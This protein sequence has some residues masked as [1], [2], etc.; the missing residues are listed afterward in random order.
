MS[1]DCPTPQEQESSLRN[2]GFPAD[3]IPYE[4]DNRRNVGYLMALT[5]PIDFLI[6][7]DDDNLC[8]AEEVFF[9]THSGNC[10]N[11]AGGWRWEFPHERCPGRG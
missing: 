2:V 10:V 6:S 7:I 9:A 3:L 5:Q 1:I 11:F 4:S 8:P